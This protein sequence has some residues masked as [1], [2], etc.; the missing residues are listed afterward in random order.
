[1]TQ[2]NTE[3]K[4]EKLG[5][6][7]R[8]MKAVQYV[9][10]EGRITNNEYQK[11]NEITAKTSFRDIEELVNFGILKKMGENKGTYYEFHVQ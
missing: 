11:L 9:E 1:M 8:Q 2:K 5:L 6:N 3:E 10:K 4:L 7:Q